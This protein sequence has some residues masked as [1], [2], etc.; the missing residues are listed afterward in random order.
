MP[1]H[2]RPICLMTRRRFLET[3][4]LTG[5][6]AAA[7]GCIPGSSTTTSLPDS[8][9]L[10]P[11]ATSPNLPTLP[12]TATTVPSPAATATALPPTATP[13]FAYKALV[14]IEKAAS[15]DHATVRKALQ[16]LLD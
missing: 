14:G 10:S 15:Y 12:Q 3:L 1:A 4:V 16:A 2:R 9:T 6:G 5:A 7:A 8:P 13:T 11:S